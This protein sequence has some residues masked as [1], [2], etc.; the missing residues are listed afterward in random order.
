[1]KRIVTLTASAAV[2]AA[3]CLSLHSQAQQAPAAPPARAAGSSGAARSSDLAGSGVHAISLPNIATELPPGPSAGRDAAGTACTF[4]HSAQ[5]ILD[6][7]AFPRQTWTNEVNK[8]RT[9]YGAP[10]A[11]QQ[12]PGIVDY[13]VT[14]RGVPEPKPEPKAQP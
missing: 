4:C 8:M 2:L 14:I 10:I 5:Y 3:G 1:M 11:E 12:V 9:T 6:Q 13:L 7:P